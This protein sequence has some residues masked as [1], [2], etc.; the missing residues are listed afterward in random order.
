M[1]K[2]PVLGAVLVT[3]LVIPAC[4]GSSDSSKVAFGDREFGMTDADYTAHVERTQ[5]LMASCMKRAG[6]DYVPVDV[7]TIQRAQASVRKEPGLS[8][9]QY[10]EK[11]GFAVTTRFDDPVFTIGLG[12]N[13][14]TMAALPPA[15]RTAYQLT[16]VG[17]NKEANFPFALDD[18]DFSDTGGCTRE[19]VSQVFTPEQLTG[20][21]VNPKDG[22]LDQDSRMR[23]ARDK[24]AN[25]MQDQG[26]PYKDDGDI[27][28]D[29]KK[30]LGALVGEG[31]PAELTGDRLD[32]L[33]AMQ[34]DEI[35]VSLVEL[36]CKEKF[37]DGTE[38]QVETEMFGHPLN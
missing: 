32:K 19:A 29:F 8:E 17:P 28:D 10:R 20:G 22:L 12:P 35:R 16:L 26:F 13:A 2:T 3:V 33:H 11:Y 31:D 1:W 37:L 38:K 30:R 18:E 5:D 36:D 14:Q 34:A 25:C 21:Y 15:Q 24:W 23:E 6:F 27:V 4:G 9:R 7:A